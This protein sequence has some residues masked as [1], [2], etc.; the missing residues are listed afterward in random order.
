MDNQPKHRIER[1]ESPWWWFG[2]PWQRQP[3]EDPPWVASD[4]EAADED[5]EWMRAMA[6]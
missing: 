5:E 1:S 3:E 6:E 2:Q 4:V